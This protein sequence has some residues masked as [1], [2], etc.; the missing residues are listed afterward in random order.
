MPDPKDPTNPSAEPRFPPPGDGPA[1]AGALA[2]RRGA[3]KPKLSRAVDDPEAYSMPFGDHLEDLRRRVIW[4]LLGIAP[5]FVICLVF[6]RQLVDILAVPAIKQLRAAGQPATMQGVSPVEAFAVYFKVATIVT[7]AIGL[8][9]IMLQMWKFVAPGLYAHE[10]RFAH[11]LFPMSFLLS[12]AGL[13]FLYFVMLPVMLAFLIAFG[14]SMGK[15]AVTHVPVPEGVVLPTVPT[16]GGDPE[17]PQAGQMW[18]NVERNE[19]RVAV[20]GEGDMVRVMAQPFGSGSTIEQKY[21]IS[22]YVGLVFMLSL[23]FVVGFQMPVV[24]LLLGWI[25]LIDREFLVRQRRM[26]I[27]VCVIAA[28][29]ITPTGDPFSLVLLAVPLVLLYELG[30]FLL[31]FLPAHRVARGVRWH[32]PWRRAAAASAGAQP[33]EGPDAGDA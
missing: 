20:P 4:S 7:L 28:A 9:W 27:L 18:F 33:R 24:V 13:A 6:G 21:R 3:G 26:A 11:L 17:A 12:M 16:L 32:V 14:T 25:G 2:R 22:E 23:A 1:D 30:L 15:V 31:K 29:I 19:L 10:R 5:V 8:P